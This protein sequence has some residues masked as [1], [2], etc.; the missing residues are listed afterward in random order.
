M[1]YF[2]N[3]TPKRG[4]RGPIPG[5]AALRTRWG[6]CARGDAFP[7]GQPGLKELPHRSHSQF[8]DE[9]CINTFI[10]SYHSQFVD[11]TQEV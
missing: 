6:M 1:S 10:S 9:S 7:K 11:D 8:V 2:Q 3:P 4:I 5:P